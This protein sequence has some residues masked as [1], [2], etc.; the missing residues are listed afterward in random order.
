MASKNENKKGL[1][2]A[3]ICTTLKL[4]ESSKFFVNKKYSDGIMTKKEW[5]KIFAKEKLSY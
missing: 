1:T 4:N 2:A 3:Q 5:E